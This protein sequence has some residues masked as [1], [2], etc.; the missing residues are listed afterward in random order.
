MAYLILV[1]FL[2]PQLINLRDL[3]QWDVYDFV[4]SCC[5]PPQRLYQLLFPPVVCHCCCTL[6]NFASCPVFQEY[7]FTSEFNQHLIL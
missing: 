6:A 7:L 3:F 4:S 1:Y 2:N 5:C